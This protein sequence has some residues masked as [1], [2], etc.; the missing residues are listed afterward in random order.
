MDTLLEYLYFEKSPQIERSCRG[1][2]DAAHTRI[3]L[4]WGGSLVYP[5]PGMPGPVYSRISWCNSL[6]PGYTQL[7]GMLDSKVYREKGGGEKDRKEKTTQK[8]A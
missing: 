7:T 3:G 6:G 4:K 8:Q 2:R 5:G 1:L